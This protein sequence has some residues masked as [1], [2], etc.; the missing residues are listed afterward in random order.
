[1]AN[2]VIPKKPRHTL[3]YA[4]YD[5]DRNLLTN[6]FGAKDHVGKQSVKKLRDALTHSISKS[7]VGELKK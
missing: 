4:G 6:L 5:F 1:M 7:A 3:T 2:V